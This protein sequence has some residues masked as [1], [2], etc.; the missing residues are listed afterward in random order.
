MIP[1]KPNLAW[2]ADARKADGSTFLTADEI[3]ASG[4]GVAL[5]SYVSERLTAAAADDASTPKS[6]AQFA[7]D[8][9]TDRVAGQTDGG[10]ELSAASVQMVLA[11]VAHLEQAVAVGG[12]V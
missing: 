2:L 9:L 3:I 10:V 6:W 4:G 11:Y 1:P 8:H 7:I 12:A 5:R